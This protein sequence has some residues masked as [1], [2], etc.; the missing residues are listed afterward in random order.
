[1]SG[2]TLLVIICVLLGGMAWYSQYS[3]KNKIY[4]VFHRAN[5]TRIEK[6]IK[7]KS[8]YVYFEGGEYVV[9]TSK[10]ELTWYNRGI[11]SIFPSFVPSLEF[12]YASRYPLDTETFK[13][14]WYTPEASKAL[15]QEKNIRDLD[16]ATQAQSGQKTSGLSKYLPWITLALLAVALM[17]IYQMSNN[18][19]MLTELSQVK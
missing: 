3:L 11:N 19:A 7:E 9:D 8:K 5:K 16:K 10:I 18:V 6:F 4:C 14:S 17:W 1:M 12:T 2:S 13:Q 15:T